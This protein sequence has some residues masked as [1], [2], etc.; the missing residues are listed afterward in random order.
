MRHAINCA[1]A[2]GSISA[3]MLQHAATGSRQHG[4]H[5]PIRVLPMLPTAAVVRPGMAKRVLMATNA[6][7]SACGVA[8]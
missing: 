2:A 3:A 7:V 1:P 5:H 4:Q 8:L 6:G